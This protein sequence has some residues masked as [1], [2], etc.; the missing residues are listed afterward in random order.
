MPALDGLRGVAVAGVLLFH[1]G[2]LTGGY[3]GVD[4]FFVLSGFLITSLLLVEA[5]GREHVRLGA[6]WARRARR[7][8]PAL[9]G[10]LL[11]VALYC[12]T[13][14]DAAGLDR[15]RGD[16]LA[17]MG[18]VANWRAVFASQDYWALFAEPSPLQHTWSLAIEEQFYL[19]W[20]L[21]VV[22]LLTWWKRA[23]TRAVL[24]VAL[25]G[26]AVSAL[27]LAALYDASDTNRAYFGTD[28]RASGILLGAALAAALVVRGPARSR[29][30]R[31]AVELAGLAGVAG[32][33]VAW[34][35]LSGE[36]AALYRGGL[37]ACGV[38]A[39]AVIA[40]GAHPDAGPIARVLSVRPLRA[41]GLISYGVYLWH[42]PVY[43]ALS[44]TRTGLTGWPLLGVRVL[45][46]L[47]IA[48][49]SYAFLEQPIRRG[50]FGP[51]VWR[52]TLPAAAAGIVAVVLLATAAGEPAL[53]A[54]STRPDSVRD[55][56]ARAAARPDA[57]RVMI[58]GNSLGY[59]LGVGMKHAGAANGTVVFNDAVVGCVF[60]HGDSR[61][62]RGERVQEHPRC[63]GNWDRA[64]RRFRPDVVFLV[65]QCCASEYRI[66]GAWLEPC[67]GPYATRYATELEVAARR[68][69]RTGARLVVATAPYT[70]QEEVDPGYRHS[71]DCSNRL[72][73]HT[74]RALDL[75]VADVNR[76]LCPQGP[77]CRTEQ[78]GVTLRP[79]HV[80]F[81]G[82]GAV[83]VSKWL[84][85]QVGMRADPAAR[86]RSAVVESG[87]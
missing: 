18:Y 27:L 83:L 53:S 8:L 61:P 15:I 32:L 30:G 39:V 33:A 64:V 9:G 16:A 35:Q 5:E 58:V 6:F 73:V 44:A 82:P 76:W 70:P 86:V 81:E 59:L 7:L 55:A 24:T 17:T 41:L 29:A 21:V 72:L 75:Q 37:V 52:A 14:A 66:D 42:W 60:P 68:L 38:A 62:L 23:V 50:A 25:G 45:V 54:A 36:S 63:D 71:L 13:V 1:G 48:G 49:A 28:T 10:V 69:T 85:D 26:A 80:H 20:P 51:R 47:V 79:D 87:E 46:T 84:L 12:V 56:A 11:G 40:A 34:T 57:R 3:L 19:V 67:S 74:A 31:A 78:D 43:L 4:L 65:Q 2:H 77:R 22:G